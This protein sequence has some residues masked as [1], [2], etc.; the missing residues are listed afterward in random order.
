M[1]LHRIGN[2]YLGSKSYFSDLF[3]N[4]HIQNAT[5][6]SGQRRGWTV[7]KVPEPQKGTHW[8]ILSSVKFPTLSEWIPHSVATMWHSVADQKI[9][10]RFHVLTTHHSQDEPTGH[11]WGHGSA[12]SCSVCMTKRWVHI[13]TL[14]VRSCNFDYLRTARLHR[15][16][17]QSG[18]D[19]LRVV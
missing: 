6:R 7:P 2:L 1:L 18:Q 19:K 12:I 8:G 17:Y 15:E 13:S 14:V 4:H 16:K 11:L 5:L 10:A 9:T 3:V